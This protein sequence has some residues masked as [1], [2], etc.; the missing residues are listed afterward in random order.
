MNAPWIHNSGST[1]NIFVISVPISI[2]IFAF[3]WRQDLLLVTLFGLKRLFGMKF[4][5]EN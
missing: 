3:K 4:T 2:F 5:I 1:G